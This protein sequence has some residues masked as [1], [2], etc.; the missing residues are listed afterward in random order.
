[1]S[2][3]DTTRELRRTDTVNIPNPGP[4]QDYV[5]VSKHPEDRPGV[6][7]HRIDLEEPD[8]FPIHV[9]RSISYDPVEGAHGSVTQ[10]VEEECGRCGYDRLTRTYTVG[11]GPDADTRECN[12]CGALSHSEGP[13]TQP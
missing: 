13:F 3:N 12:A 6:K 5:D 8:D 7:S 2:N 1:M 4:G 9:S 11:V 10:I